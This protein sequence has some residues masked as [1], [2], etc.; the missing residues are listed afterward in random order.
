MPIRD[1]DF[2]YIRQL[3][4][5]H[6]SVTLAE[7]K[8]Y[9][10]DSRLAS[11]AKQ[12]GVIS[13]SNLVRKLRSQPF[14]RLHRQAIESVMTTESWFFRDRHPFETLQNHII[15]ELI[16]KRQNQTSLNIWCAGCASG[17]EPYS[18][19]MLLREHFPQLAS[20]RVSLIA[21][22]ISNKILNRACQGRYNHYEITRGLT[23]YLREKYFQ[24]QGKDWQIETDIRQMVEFRQFN[25]TNS[26][27]LLPLMDIIFLRN[28]LIYF[29][30][31]MKQIILAKVRELLKPEGYLFL[32]GGETT[33][34]LDQAFKPVQFNKT[35]YY[36]LIYS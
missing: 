2:R 23:P 21:S 32:G 11:L 36:Q 14:N 29:E 33:I 18:I 10:V 17:Q 15:P 30:V 1:A 19:A 24:L 9:L 7:D 25:L 4:K 5:T 34:N 16:N 20:R 12:V 3:V 6:T 28:V 35:T 27:P 22:D 13:V 26:W 31:D 8:A